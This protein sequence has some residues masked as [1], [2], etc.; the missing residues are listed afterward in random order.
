[1]KSLFR[2]ICLVFLTTFLPQDAAAQRL[3]NGTQFGGWTVSCEALAVNET[4]CVLSQR[5]VRAGDG[6]LL[7]DLLA[8]IS[9]DEPAAWVAARLPNGVFF[10]SGFSLRAD[11]ADTESERIVS[12]E[13][14][15]CSPE[16]CE[17]LVQL[18]PDTARD[19]D[20][21]EDW[22]AAYRPAIDADPLVFRM[23]PSGLEE[24]LSALAG[25]LGHPDP[26]SADQSVTE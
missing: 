26:F 23:D 12:F 6:G 9:A 25:A 16:I 20:V 21:L 14:Q 19:F 5:L 1:M 4:V 7:A 24:G 18:S 13:W 17:A 15:S 22:V 10:P 11:D 2:C 8:F 3:V